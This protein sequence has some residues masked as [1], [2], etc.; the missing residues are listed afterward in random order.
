[1]CLF[2]YEDDPEPEEQVPPAPQ[3]PETATRN[4]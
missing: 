4:A 3:A 1:M 2:Q